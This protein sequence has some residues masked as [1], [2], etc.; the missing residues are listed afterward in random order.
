[1]FTSE[2]T[3]LAWDFGWGWKVLAALGF[4]MDLGRLIR[5][6]GKFRLG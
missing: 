2:V 1:V 6:R 3:A 4:C 5:I